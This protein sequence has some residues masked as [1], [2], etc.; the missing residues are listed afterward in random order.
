MVQVVYASV[1]LYRTRGDQLDRYGYAAFGLTVIPYIVMSMVNLLGNLLTPEYPNL[2]LVRS[3]E[4]TE[5]ESQ[6]GYFEATIGEVVDDLDT[7]R[8]RARIE[9]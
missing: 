8:R 4:M 2:Y 1:T 5:A 7:P 6:G 3:K 9:S